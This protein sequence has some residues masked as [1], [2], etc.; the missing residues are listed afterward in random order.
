MKTRYL[1][2]AL[3]LVI[4]AGAVTTVL[5]HTHHGGSG[6]FGH[7]LG[8]IARKLDLSAAQRTQ[9]KSMIQAERPNFEPLVQQLA[10]QQQQMLALTRGGSFDQAQV[11][12][13]ADQQAQTLSE[14]IVIRERVIANVYKNVLTSE[15]RTKADSLREHMAEHMLRRF[16]EHSSQTPP[17]K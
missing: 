4:A 7:R 12:T 17:A 16:Q 11:K 1:A 10:G 8:F 15:Q 3:G 6:M 13:L 9:I 14:L 5:A 2:I